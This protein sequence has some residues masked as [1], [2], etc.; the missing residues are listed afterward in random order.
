MSFDVGGA[1][2]RQ[3][4]VRCA[5]VAQTVEIEVARG[6]ERLESVGEVLQGDAAEVEV[7]GNATGFPSQDGL[8]A[9][10]EVFQGE[11]RPVGGNIAVGTA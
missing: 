8:E 2:L 9:D 4:E 7:F 3:G 11:F 1:Q 6:K 5:D 10:G